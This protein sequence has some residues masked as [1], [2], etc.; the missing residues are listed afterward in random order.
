[1]RE[2]RWVV[3]VAL[4]A[5]LGCARTPAVPIS[6]TP[7]ARRLSHE[8]T[9]AWIASHHAW[10]AARKSKPMWARAVR[11]DEIGKAFQTADHAVEHATDGHWLCVGVAGEPWFQAR[12]KIQAKYV[13]TAAERRQ[14]SFDA[15]PRDYQVFTPRQGV[16]NWAARVDDPAI[17]GFYVQPSY[18]TD[19][20]LYS[21]RGGYVVRDDA[22]DP[23]ATAPA[24][25]W[26]V[27][28]PLFE[29]TDQIDD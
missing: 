13:R 18:P 5:A 28:Q 3:G 20:P 25:V 27:Q 4:L 26:L 15:A 2:R 8:E 21:P 22:R 12:A 24:D 19:R 10:R 7:T 9:L 1:M 11:P 6:S 23:Y 17:E 16:R 29:S 14:F